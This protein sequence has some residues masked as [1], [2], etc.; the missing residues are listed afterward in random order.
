MKLFSPLQNVSFGNFDFNL[1]NFTG[2]V[3]KHTYT[4]K[5][6]HRHAHA[7]SSVDTNDV[8]TVE[9]TVVKLFL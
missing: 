6:I 8:L 4:Q 9:I 1:F 3:H 5:E 7:R 2:A